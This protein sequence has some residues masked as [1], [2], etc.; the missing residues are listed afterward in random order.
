MI[1]TVRDVGGAVRH[2]R[3]QAGLSQDQLAALAHV[4]RPWL[5]RL[6]TGANPGAELRKVLDVVAALGLTIDLTPAPQPT[7]DDDDPFA[8]LFGGSS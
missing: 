2:A 5:S 7:S 1:S 4:S 6:E 8:D 3:R